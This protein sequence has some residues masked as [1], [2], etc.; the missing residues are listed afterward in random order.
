MSHLQFI[1]ISY[2]LTRNQIF[3]I[4][5]F[6]MKQALPSQVNMFNQTLECSLSLHPMI[7]T[8]M[9]SNC[10]DC[11]EERSE[12]FRFFFYVDLLIYTIDD[13]VTGGIPPVIFSLKSL[14]ELH[15]EFNAITMVPQAINNLQNLKV[16]NLNHNPLLESLPGSLGHL[17][18][19]SSKTIQ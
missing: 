12:L 11:L 18:N 5:N 19:I 4:L 14:V 9:V 15:L 16:L 2:S 1:Q 10:S 13:E 6:C 8:S 3:H 7:C 17:P